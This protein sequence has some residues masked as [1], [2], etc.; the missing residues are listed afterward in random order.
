VIVVAKWV[1]VFAGI[2]LV[3]WAPA[4]ITQL[5]VQILVLL[6]L[7]VENFYHHAQLL[8]RRPVPDV[9]AY[10]ASGADLAVVTILVSLQ[11]GFDS[12]LY[13]FYFPALI[14]LS[15][16]FRTAIT[17]RFTAATIGLYTLI[18]LVDFSDG[19]VTNNDFQIM[20]ARIGMMAGLVTCGALSYRLEARRRTTGTAANPAPVDLQR[21]PSLLAS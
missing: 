9:V 2:L 14:A 1:L 3:L 7:A 12:N 15:V 6:L 19:T 8:K 18:C 4:P 21:T 10:I 5:R 11:G 20:L 16:V 13:I 17:A